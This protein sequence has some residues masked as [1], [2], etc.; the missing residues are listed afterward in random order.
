MKASITYLEKQV[1]IVNEW[2]SSHSE[3]HPDYKKEKSKR[4]YYVG[5]IC[6]MDEYDLTTIEI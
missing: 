2:L 5:K 1:S 4:D 6:E 3:K